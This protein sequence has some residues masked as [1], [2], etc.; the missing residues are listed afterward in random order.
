[1]MP[2]MMLDRPYQSELNSGQPQNTSPYT[3]DKD[4]PTVGA[5]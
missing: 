2:G 1:M 3:L 5:L 4:S